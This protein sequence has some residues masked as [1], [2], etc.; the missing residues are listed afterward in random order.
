[1]SVAVLAL[2]PFARGVTSE[3]PRLCRAERAG[4][5]PA[6]PIDTREALGVVVLVLT[7]RLRTEACKPPDLALSSCLAVMPMYLLAREPAVILL[8]I[9]AFVEVLVPSR[10]FCGLS[11]LSLSAIRRV[12][13]RARAGVLVEGREADGVAR[14]EGV[15][16]P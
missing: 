7:P 12:T 3:L 5:T 14:P 2:G 8:S 10:V 6:I 1:M 16:R 15:L 9:P 4:V 13:T 11:P